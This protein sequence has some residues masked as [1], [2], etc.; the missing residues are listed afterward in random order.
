MIQVNYYNP[1]KVLP[2]KEYNQLTFS[3]NENQHL[4]LSNV[5][6][7]SEIFSISSSSMRMCCQRMS[8]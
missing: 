6:F 7:S 4:S 8:C 3:S 1:Q 5:T 2:R